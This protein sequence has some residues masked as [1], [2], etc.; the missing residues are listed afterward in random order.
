MSAKDAHIAIGK[1]DL[2]TA[3]DESYL[4]GLTYEDLKKEMPDDVAKYEALRRCGV[5][6]SYRRLLVFEDLGISIMDNNTPKDFKC[7]KCDKDISIFEVGYLGS[8][9][10]SEECSAF[11]QLKCL[12]TICHEPK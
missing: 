7:D 6:Q 11:T 5:D 2:E 10:K 3:Q 12:C 4:P 8:P 1:V 9:D